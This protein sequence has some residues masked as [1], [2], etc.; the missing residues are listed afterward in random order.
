MVKECNCVHE[1]NEQVPI[2]VMLDGSVTDVRF[3]QWEKAK[4]GIDVRPH[5]II[6]EFKKL[7]W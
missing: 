3:V 4:S 7:Q 1:L 5:G 2:D 6:T